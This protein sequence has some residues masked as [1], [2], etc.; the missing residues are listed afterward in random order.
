VAE[1]NLKFI[2]D[3]VS[4]IEVGRTGRAYVVDGD[5]RLIAHPDISLVLRRTGLAASP[6]V[7]AALA[8]GPTDQPITALDPEGRQAL[9]AYARI[10]PLGWFVFADLPVTEAYQP[11]YASMLR[12]GGL[13]LGG[14]LLAAL[15]GL[16]LARRMT[17]P[18][19]RLQ[20]SAARIG[21]G[22]L[23]DRI[24]IETGDELEALAGD[25]NRM[26]AR[27]CQPRAQG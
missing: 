23:T 10:E 21:S 4:R 1:V 26:A 25:F 7:A 2:W 6:Q 9:S 3:V 24:E 8:G 13:V 18:I 14:V 15:A 12:T 17:G 19:H 27:L 20:E 16:M 5:G 11:L 22:D